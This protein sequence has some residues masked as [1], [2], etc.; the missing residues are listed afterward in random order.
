VPYTILTAVLLLFLLLIWTLPLYFRLSYQRHEKN[1]HIIVETTALGKIVR[2]RLEIPVTQLVKRKNGWPWVETEFESRGGEKETE[3]HALEEQEK[4]WTWI[5]FA[6]HNY[7]EVQAKINRLMTIVDDY[8]D[9][10]R[11]LTNKIRLKRFYW[12]TRIGLDDAAATAITVGGCWAIKSYLTATLWHRHRTARVRPLIRV[13]PAYNQEIFQTDFECIFSIRL[14]H[15]IG[16]G[17]RLL[18]Y[19]I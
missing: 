18:R 3:T 8:A 17:I 9:F 13:I 11:W 19:K 2:Y 12:V 16:A 1:D 14:G 5:R 10:M 7:D 6:L 4:S 15:I